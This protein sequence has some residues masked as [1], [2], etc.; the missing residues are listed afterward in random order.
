MRIQ[1]HLML[2]C[3][4]DKRAFIIVRCRYRYLWQT[5]I[6]TWSMRK[7]QTLLHNAIGNMSACL[8]CVCVK[9]R[10]QEIPIF[11]SIWEQ[12]SFMVDTYSHTQRRF[13]EPINATRHS[14]DIIYIYI[15]Q[16]CLMCIFIWCQ[17]GF[18]VHF[19]WNFPP[20]THTHRAL[21]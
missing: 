18:F 14:I 8:L 16:K 12:Y 7:D 10:M 11:Y 6:T 1:L 17:L 9:Q 20:D 3:S 15:S 4:R 5:N 13:H 2:Y 21:P 19:A